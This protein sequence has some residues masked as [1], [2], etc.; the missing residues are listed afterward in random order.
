LVRERIRIQADSSQ[1]MSLMSEG[2]EMYGMQTF[3]QH[4]Y[5]L[6]EAEQI[7]EETA[8]AYASSA[9]DLSLRLR[10]LM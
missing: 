7:S 2:R 10:G 8:L 9:K 4:L 6:W 5:E 1:I 3:D